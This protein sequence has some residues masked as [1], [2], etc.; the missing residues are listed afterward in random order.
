M[1]SGSKNSLVSYLF[2]STADLRFAKSRLSIE[3]M[4]LMS[5]RGK[6][7]HDGIW[8]QKAQNHLVVHFTRDY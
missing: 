3:M 6:L 4:F 8:I 2:A 5:C 7:P 1:V